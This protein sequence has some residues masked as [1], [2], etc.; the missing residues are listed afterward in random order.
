M[1]RAAAKLITM[2]IVSKNLPTLF[3]VMSW[4]YARRGFT[5]VMAV[6]VQLTFVEWKKTSSIKFAYH[7]IFVLES[8][9]K[10]QVMQVKVTS[11]KLP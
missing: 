3:A 7:K 1:D 8:L 6:C 10:C 11:K 2:K 5:R 4:V 9:G